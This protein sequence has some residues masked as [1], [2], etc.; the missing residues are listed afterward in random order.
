MN[1]QDVREFR[2]RIKAITMKAGAT[3]EEA[4]VILSRIGARLNGHTHIEAVE[5]FPDHRPAP[6]GSI[7]DE[8]DRGQ[9]H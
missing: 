5:M 4:E 1:E 8:A 7:R 6:E 9:P 3:D 2:E